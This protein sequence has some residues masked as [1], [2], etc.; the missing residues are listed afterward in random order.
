MK[1]ADWGILRW[2][3]LS[4]GLLALGLSVA[5]YKGLGAWSQA[6]PASDSAAEEN[7]AVTALSVPLPAAEAVAEIAQHSLF[8]LQRGP[9]MQSYGS[10]AV[11]AEST[12][13]QNW[14]LLSVMITPALTMAVIKASDQRLIRI[15]QGETIPGSTWQFDRAERRA[16]VLVGPSGEQ[17]L[18]LQ[19]YNGLAGQQGPSFST[20]ANQATPV[21]STD[22]SSMPPT[23]PINSEQAM[24]QRLEQRRAELQ[25]P[26]IQ[27]QHPL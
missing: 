13:V 20:P 3:T 10:A 5:A 14:Q 2:L 17:R 12:P 27:R 19:T 18:E 6:L 21:V 7:P 26:P 11:L 8:S 4:A 15:K 25:H 9:D 1:L 24:R 22:S 16:I 23:P